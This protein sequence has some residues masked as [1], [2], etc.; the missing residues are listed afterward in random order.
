MFLENVPGLAERILRNFAI[1]TVDRRSSS[2][3][4]GCNVVPIEMAQGSG[5]AACVSWPSSA[6]VMPRRASR[7]TRTA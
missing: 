3:P 5:A 4:S 6:G 7:G 1:R 2:P